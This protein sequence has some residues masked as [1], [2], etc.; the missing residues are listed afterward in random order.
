LAGLAIGAERHEVVAEEVQQVTGRARSARLV[1]AHPPG[2]ERDAWV[3]HPRRAVRNRIRE[4]AV[5]GGLGTAGDARGA[6]AVLVKTERERRRRRQRRA[7]LRVR[8][9]RRGDEEKEECASKVFHGGSLR[10]CGPPDNYA[11]PGKATDPDHEC[12][13]RGSECPAQS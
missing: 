1:Y 13:R 4:L 10:T 6:R 5:V 3:E 9:R 2:R 12:C 7:G 8:N 11:S